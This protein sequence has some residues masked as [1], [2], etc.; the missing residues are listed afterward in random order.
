MKKLILMATV[1]A[2]GSSVA[3][4]QETMIVDFD[5]QLNAISNPA[6]YASGRWF[7]SF[8]DTDSSG[9]NNN[10]GWFTDPSLQ[11]SGTQTNLST[12]TA[13]SN[14]STPVGNG[15]DNLY[16]MKFSFMAPWDPLNGATPANRNTDSNRTFLRCYTSQNRVANPGGVPDLKAP[17]LDTTKKFR[18][19]I[20]SVKSLRVAALISEGA[21]T[22]P[23]IGLAGSVAAPLEL[24]AGKIG[25]PNALKAT[26][27]AGGFVIP[28]G[29]WTTVVFD[30]QD[31]P[32]MRN[33]SGGDAVLNPVTPGWVS[34]SSL[35]FTPAAGN[36]AL[37]DS[38]EVFIDN[39]RQGD[40]LPGGNLT[41]TLT[42]GD[43][44]G[45]VAAKQAKVELYNG[46]TLVETYTNVALD[47]SGNFS[48]AST[49]ATGTYDVYIEVQNGTWLRRKVGSVSVTTGSASG[50]NAALLN[51]NIISDTVIDLSDYTKLVTYFNKTDVDSD[52]NTPDGDGIAPSRADITG[53][54]VVDLTDYTSVVTNFNSIAD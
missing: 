3:F 9:S 10:I 11:T 31:T 2:I 22:S 48:I 43:F 41:G 15:N 49:V 40:P 24:I 23:A 32:S 33:F 51:G 7:F 35:I 25:G 17:M 36:E 27:S 4:A 18:F 28:A 13:G 19:D 54:G 1:A 52:W 14:P 5:N 16:R 53:D 20:Y 47:A 44:S 50:I 34:L 30:F 29:T 46:A 42:L 6:T 37:P 8:I 39:L 21:V 12:I 26:G 45:N 38:Q